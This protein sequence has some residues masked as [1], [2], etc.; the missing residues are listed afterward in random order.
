M[1]ILS[2]TNTYMTMIEESRHIQSVQRVGVAE[3]PAVED[4]LKF[5]LEFQAE[6]E[7]GKTELSPLKE[8]GYRKFFPYLFEISRVFDIYI[9]STCY[10]K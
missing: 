10:I 5:P 1:L 2:K 9:T 4:I 8:R 6:I 7:L 3:N